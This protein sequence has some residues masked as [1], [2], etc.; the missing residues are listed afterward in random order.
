MWE[1]RTDKQLA[2]EADAGMRGQGPVVE[3]MC[4]LRNVLAEQQRSTN[5]LTWI[6]LGCT[7][8]LVILTFVLVVVAVEPQLSIRHDWF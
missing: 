7:I 3:A 4:R 5:R 2:Q 8:V 6:I 1:D